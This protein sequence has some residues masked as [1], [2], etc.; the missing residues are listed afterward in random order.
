MDLRNYRPDT[1]MGR[2]A[3]HHIAGA[4]HS[5]APHVAHGFEAIQ[6]PLPSLSPLQPTAVPQ[7]V[8]C[9][10]VAPLDTSAA[11]SDTGR[12]SSVLG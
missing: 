8:A 3:R 12:S 2:R 7:R 11:A 10:H 1:D 9:R 5:T 4:G 6:E